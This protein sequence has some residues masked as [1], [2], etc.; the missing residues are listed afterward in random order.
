M[1]FIEGWPAILVEKPVKTI[2]ISDLHFG[3]EAE[4]ADRGVRVP[5]QAWKLRELLIELIK[6]VDAERLIFLGDLKHRIPLSSWIEWREMPK[7]I[8]DLKRFV[9]LIL[10]PGNHDGGIASMLG[11]LIT[12]ASSRGVLIEAEQKIFLLHGHTWPSK[13]VLKADLVV[14]GHLH[15]MV[16]L[17][18]DV[19]GVFK[20]RVWLILEGDRRVLAERLGARSGRRKKLKLIVMPAF[21]PILTGISVNSITPRDRLWPLMRGGGFELRQAELIT[22]NGER[23]GRVGELEHQLWDMET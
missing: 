21:N 6:E 18:T 3:F 11:D 16:S 14:M 7:V 22:L 4:L 15:P 10:V 5:S 2:L 8:K 17:R 13:D 23:L 20:K 19:G 12:Y 9:D 1:R